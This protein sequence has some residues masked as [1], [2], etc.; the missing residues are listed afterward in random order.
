MCGRARRCGKASIAASAVAISACTGAKLFSNAR[1]NIA[2]AAA[3]LSA[4][5]ITSAAQPK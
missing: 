2:N 4:V 5:A 3:T 1:S